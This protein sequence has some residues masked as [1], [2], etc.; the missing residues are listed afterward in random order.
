MRGPWSVLTNGMNLISLEPLL[1]F[2]TQND[3]FWHFGG[4]NTNGS[5]C[6]YNNTHWLPLA[7]SEWVL[8]PLVV[9]DWIM[10]VKVLHGCFKALLNIVQLKVLLTLLELK[11]LIQALVFLNPTIGVMDVWVFI[12]YLDEITIL[13]NYFIV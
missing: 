6:Y 13:Y 12:L 5:R 11:H 3:H 9:L 8:S 10:S 1:K 7:F 2:L 4:K